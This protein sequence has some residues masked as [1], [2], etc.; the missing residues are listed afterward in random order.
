VADQEPITGQAA[1]HDLGNGAGGE[2]DTGLA[3]D[4]APDIEEEGEET[5]HG[6]EII[7][8]FRSSRRLFRHM[9]RIFSHQERGPEEF[10]G[11]T[12]RY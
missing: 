4:L 10:A 11:K 5:F 8:N 9:S 7:Q 12:E 3:T 6:R 1:A 2:V